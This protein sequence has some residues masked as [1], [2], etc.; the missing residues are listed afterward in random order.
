MAT[1]SVRKR[2]LSSAAGERGRG[3][4]P[5]LPGG[6]PVPPLPPPP[7]TAT[8]GAGAADAGAN[9]GGAEDEVMGGG[10]V[11]SSSRMRGAKAERRC[12]AV[13]ASLKRARESRTA[14]KSAAARLRL[15]GPARGAIAGAYASS[16]KMPRPNAVCASLKRDANV[17]ELG[18]SRK[19]RGR[20][21]GGSVKRDV[22]AWSADT[23]ERGVVVVAGETGWLPTHPLLP[24]SKPGRGAL[25]SPARRE[26]NSARAV[27]G[28]RVEGEPL[29][30]DVDAADAAA[31]A[32]MVA[33]SPPPPPS[34]CGSP[35]TSCK[36]LAAP[37]RMASM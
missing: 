36:K 5:G 32:A 4:E 12:A 23:E 30:F 34:C 24:P 28:G 21:E 9:A 1:C 10:T 17:V 3:E 8:A 31:T 13:D 14:F 2:E 25:P 16:V 35:M 7:T 11:V 15:K 37:C 18:A 20:E 22:S 26:D 6:L 19:R 29:P 27:E 33:V